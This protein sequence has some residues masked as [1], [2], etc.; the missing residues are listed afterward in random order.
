MAK[1]INLQYIKGLRVIANAKINLT[2]GIIGKREDGYHLIDTVMQSVTLGDKIIVKPAKKIIIKCKGLELDS[3]ENIAF[4]SAKLFFEYTG[5]NGGAE[6]TIYKKI[7]AVAGLGGGSTDAAAVLTA[8]NR[9]CN[10]VL[11]NEELEKLALNLGADVPFFIRGGTQRA[12]GIGEILT[13]LA[14][15]KKG[16]FVL[17]KGEQKPSTA[18]MY[19]RLDSETPPLPKTDDFIDAYT[20]GDYQ[21]AAS[22]FGNSFSAV[23]QN[24]ET[25]NNLV[26]ANAQCISLSGSGPTWFSYFENKKAAKRVYKKL[27]SQNK[28][29]YI[30]K[31]CDFAIKCD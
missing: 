20:N 10:K 22:L 29:C 14:D 17:T 8:L 24:S 26:K 12:E 18:Q 15:F 16:Y 2:L 31:P 11:S 23:W 28:E 19:K 1:K 13:P 30:V 9:L 6:I 21:K 5:I 3:K 25:Y 27:K 4:K 7:P